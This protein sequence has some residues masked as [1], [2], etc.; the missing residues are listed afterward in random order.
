MAASYAAAYA[1][2]WTLTTVATHMAARRFTLIGDE[3]ERTVLTSIFAGA[4]WPI[5]IIGLLEAVMLGLVAS[6]RAIRRPA[7][8]FPAELADVVA[9]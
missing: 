9:L 6:L 1:V 8:T 3:P 7:P 5:M 4:L 2:A